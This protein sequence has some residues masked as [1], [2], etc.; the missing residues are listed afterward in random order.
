M[1]EL[2]PVAVLQKRITQASKKGST[3]LRR[4]SESFAEPPVGEPA[5]ADLGFAEANEEVCSISFNSRSACSRLRDRSRASRAASF[6]PR[7]KSQRGDSDTN[8]LPTTNRRP[9][10]IDI[11][12]MRRHALSFTRKI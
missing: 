1:M 6:F 10:G 11:Q 5:F 9:G 3:Y 12:K 4:S 7:L 2:I 8:T